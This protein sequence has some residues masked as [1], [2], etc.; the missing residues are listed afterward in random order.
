MTSTLLSLRELLLLS[1]LERT[2]SLPRAFGLVGEVVQAVST[3][4]GA[5][6]DSPIPSIERLP[7]ADSRRML[8]D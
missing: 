8:N 4:L 1:R 2:L 6:K 5:G 7:S 3:G